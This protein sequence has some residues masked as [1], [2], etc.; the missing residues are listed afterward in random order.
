MSDPIKYN[1]WSANGENYYQD[2]SYVLDQLDV[3]C[4]IYEGVRKNP[5]TKDYITHFII[6]R[7]I[8]DMREAACEEVGE[9]AEG[10]L[11]SI[12]MK[13]KQEL[14]ELIAKWADK[15]EA[16]SFWTVEQVNERTLTAEDWK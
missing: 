16:P 6:D 7:I 12:N 14:K 11:E 13:A 8:D 3:G 9:C 2:H 10:Y 5:R 4:T 15:H 1:C